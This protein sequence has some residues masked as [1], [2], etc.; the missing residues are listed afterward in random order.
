MQELGVPGVSLAMRSGGEEASVAFGTTRAGDGN[1]VTPETRF[2]AGSITKTV[3]ATAL[4]RLLGEG[5]VDL[6]QPVAG[7]LPG[8]RLPTREATATVTLRHLL[9]HSGGF[10]GDLFIDSGGGDDALA[11][12]VAALGGVEQLSAPGRLYSYSNSGFYVAGRVLEV[13]AGRAYEDVIRALVLDPLGMGESCFTGEVKPGPAVATG[14]N[15]V[16]GRPRPVRPWAFPRSM[17]APGGLVTTARDLVRYARLQLEG[18]VAA[19]G[20]RLLDRAAAEAMRVPDRR[21]GGHVGLAWMPSKVAGTRL[22][23]HNGATSGQMASL[24]LA[25]GRDFAIAVLTNS[26]HGAELHREVTRRLLADALDLDPP[27]PP[28]LRVPDR[29]LATLAGVYRCALFELELLP[30]TDMLEMRL[31]RLR[32]PIDALPRAPSPPAVRLG[33]TGRDEVV[34][35]DPPFNRVRGQFGRGGLLAGSAR[36]PWLRWNGRVCRRPD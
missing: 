20:G 32:S 15:V 27:D 11:R 3:T 23:G 33:F 34:A 7:Y 2:Q 21:R 14:H 1:P 6:D 35:L 8:L 13:V 4:M 25:P 31:T 9:T 30:T 22:I 19:D 26:N 24:T 5:R 29:R 10:E 36:T 18:G 28:L 17:N 12:A 16:D